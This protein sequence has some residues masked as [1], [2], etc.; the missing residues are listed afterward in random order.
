MEAR[1]SFKNVKI[2]PKKL[3]FLLPAVKNMTPARAV[4]H[5]FYS[6]KRGAKI[7]YKAIRSA[8]ANAKQ[9]LKTDEH[10]LQF[11]ALFVDE[12]NTLKRYKAGG[13]GAAKPIAREFSHITVVLEAPA[14]VAS[15]KVEVKKAVEEKLTKVQ[16]KAT[17]KVTPKKKVTSRKK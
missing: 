11:K 10:L 12:G 5:L 2:A 4:E 8:M 6:N 15:K 9:T 1:A 13:K 17:E 14:S 16:T 3:R 7:L